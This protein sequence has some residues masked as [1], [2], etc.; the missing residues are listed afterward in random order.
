MLAEYVSEGGAL[1][2]LAQGT[3]NAVPRVQFL[4]RLLAEFGLGISY[5]RPAGPALVYRHPVTAGVEGLKNVPA[6]N[7]VWAFGDSPLVSVSGYAVATALEFGKGHII[8]LDGGTL[9]PQ[10]NVKSAADDS[11]VGFRRILGGAVHWLTGR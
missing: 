3:V 1:F 11:S 9:L 10:P 5:G 7:S 8:V 2:V 4:N 6:G